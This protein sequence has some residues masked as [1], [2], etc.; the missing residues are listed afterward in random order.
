MLILFVQGAPRAQSYQA[1][2]EQKEG[3]FADEGWGIDDLADQSQKWFPD[4]T[5]R[6]VVGGGNVKWSQRE[7]ETARIMWERHGD[8]YAL[9]VDPALK[10]YDDAA[11]T[12]PPGNLEPTSE[13]LRNAD[14]RLWLLM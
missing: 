3:W 7:W 6:V 10:M 14:Y 13:Q 9:V 12:R 8:T 2:M 4:A 11:A 1:E 5:T